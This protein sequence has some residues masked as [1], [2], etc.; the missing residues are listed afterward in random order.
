MI[1]AHLLGPSADETI[2]VF[3]MAMRA[4]I[5]A[6][7]IKDMLFAYPTAGSDIGYML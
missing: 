7:T 1:G 6:R 3:A 5:P 4:R 2:N